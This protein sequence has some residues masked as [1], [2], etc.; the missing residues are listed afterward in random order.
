M[1]KSFPEVNAIIKK[2]RDCPKDFESYNNQFDID[3]IENVFKSLAF[4]YTS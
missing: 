2:K 4:H 3:I 1:I